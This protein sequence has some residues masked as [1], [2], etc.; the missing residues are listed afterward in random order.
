ME[1][2]SLKAIEAELRVAVELGQERQAVMEELILHAE[3]AVS[4]A[5]AAI[6]ESRRIATLIE[7]RR[8]RVPI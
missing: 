7:A 8:A 1:E 3:Q 6:A 4:R 2:R 5:K